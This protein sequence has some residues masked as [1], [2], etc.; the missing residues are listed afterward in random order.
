MQM[1]CA[2]PSDCA[3][4]DCGDRRCWPARYRPAV[5]RISRLSTRSAASRT[6]GNQAAITRE[7]RRMAGC[8]GRLPQLA[9]PCGVTRP[10]SAKRK[11]ASR[12]SSIFLVNPS[13]SLPVHKSI[14]LAGVGGR[15]VVLA[16]LRDHRRGSSISRSTSGRFV[17]TAATAQP[18]H[19][20]RAD[21]IGRN[22]RKNDC[23]KKFEEVREA[24]ASRR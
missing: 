24:G 17:G 9:H 14:E 23:S 7:R 20:R 3:A 19:F 12:T 10:R 5:R 16:R 1:R 21:R 8:L 13:L 11:S 6:P 18:I 2:A 4:G 15:A 22:E